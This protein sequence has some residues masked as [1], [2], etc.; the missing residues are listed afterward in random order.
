MKLLSIVGARP[1]F[2]K[3]AAIAHAV[4]DHN[5][6]TASDLRIEHLIVHTGQHY[7]ER[8]STSFFED[9]SIPRPHINLEVGS[10][11]HAEQTAEIMTRFEKVLLAEL[12]DVLLVVGDVNST[13]ACAMVAAKIKYPDGSARERPV[14]VH[15]EAGLRSFDREMPEEINRVLTD[16]ISDMLFVT[17]ESALRNLGH[18]GVAAGRV[19]FVGNVM[20]D[21]L[22]RHLEKARQSTA[23]QRFGITCEYGIVTLHRPSNVDR[24]EL[25]EPILNALA[26]ISDDLPLYF[27]VHPRTCKAILSFGLAGMFDWSH[28]PQNPP[29]G[30]TGSGPSRISLLPPLGYLDFLHLIERSTLVIT[31]SGGIQEETTYLKVPCLTLRENTERPATI[32]IGSNVLVGTRPE[33]ILDAASK[34]LKLRAA[35]CQV[36]PLWDGKAAGRIIQGIVQQFQARDVK[37]GPIEAGV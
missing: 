13:I 2:M 26:E 33:A 4:R 23:R 35:D 15:V 3:I 16:S 29:A 14:I 27:P 34:A 20:I 19:H 22:Q 12:P 5:Q 28:H 7:D 6:N 31:D 17:E 25:I 1:N 21:T 30:S 37:Q 8:M 10:G 32:E 24:K 36:P 9:L 18:E 11:S